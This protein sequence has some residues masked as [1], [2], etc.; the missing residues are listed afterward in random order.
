MSNAISTLS[1]NGL[2]RR[3]HQRLTFCQEHIENI[4]FGFPCTPSFSTRNLFPLSSLL[5]FPLLH[6]QSSFSTNP[7][8]HKPKLYCFYSSSP[9]GARSL[10]KEERTCPPPLLEM[11]QCFLCY[12]MLSNVSVYE[13]LMHYF[14]KISSVS[15][16]SAPRP[17]PGLCLWTPLGDF[18]PSDPL[19][20]HPCG[21]PC[22][23]YDLTLQITL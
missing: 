9:G 12:K 1:T 17:S 16:A 21:C 5:H 20:A 22:S 7:R 13:V 2:R 4:N 11:L 3:I 14:K 15:E 10:G 23:S 6:F 19:I 8:Q 18:R